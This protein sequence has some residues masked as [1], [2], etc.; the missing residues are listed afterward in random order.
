MAASHRR[1]FALSA[2]LVLCALGTQLKCDFQLQSILVGRVFRQANGRANRLRRGSKPSKDKIT[3]QRSNTTSKLLA[4]GRSE[5][6]EPFFSEL[7]FDVVDNESNKSYA[8]KVW[9]D[10]SRSVVMEDNLCDAS[11]HFRE[12]GSVKCHVLLSQFNENWGAM[13]TPVPN[14]TV[15]WGD[16]VKHWKDDGCSEEDIFHYLNHSNTLAVFTVQHQAYDHPK[17]HSIPLGVPPEHVPTILEAMQKPS[18]NKTQ[19]LMINDSGWEH[20]HAINKAVI[21]NFRGMVN[22]TYGYDG[23]TEYYEEMRRSKFV[24]CPSGLGWDSYRIWETLYMGTIPVIEHYNRADGWYRTFDG[25]P[26][27]WVERMENLTPTM[28]E[29]AYVELAVNANHYS[30]EKL[31]TAYWIDMV[32]SFTRLPRPG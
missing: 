5:D 2:V 16:L 19:L 8:L 3:R 29:A 6:F 17:V 7:D 27:M 32:N 24:L 1:L 31:T 4:W 23:M 26:V 13:S 30:F 22:N 28:L 21:K 11:K 9:R 10:T 25:L 20:R 14:R 15:D 12:F 18:A